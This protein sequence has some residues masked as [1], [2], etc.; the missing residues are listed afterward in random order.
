ML[1]E[2]YNFNRQVSTPEEYLKDSIL[3]E[4]DEFELAQLLIVVVK[5]Y[6]V[7][8]GKPVIVKAHFPAIN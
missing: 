4:G 3:E 8:D 7:I 6:K 1:V 2:P 5:R